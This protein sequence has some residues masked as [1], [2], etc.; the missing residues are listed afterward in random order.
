MYAA[1]FYNLPVLILSQHRVR[2]MPLVAQPYRSS[3]LTVF[4]KQNKTLK[5]PESILVRFGTLGNYKQKKLLN[6]LTNNF[7]IMTETPSRCNSTD[8][9]RTLNKC[10]VLASEFNSQSAW[11]GTLFLIEPHHANLSKSHSKS[12]KTQQQI[13]STI[14]RSILWL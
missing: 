9:L 6:V 12:S 8:T 13:Y 14:N 3:I 4:I 5:L 1:Q 11:H 10:R 2:V 7:L